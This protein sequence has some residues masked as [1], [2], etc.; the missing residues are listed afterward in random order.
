MS[1][2]RASG[3]GTRAW[4]PGVTAKPTVVALAASDPANPYG[5]A[6]RW[7]ATTADQAHK[8]T[9]K[10]GALVVLV[11]GEPVIYLERGGHT[12]LTW[13]TE[14]NL[15][16]AASGALADLVRTGRLASLTVAKI[17]ADSAI[18]SVVPLTKALVNV[19]FTLTPKGLR[20]RR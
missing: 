13:T 6:L 8:P 17:D 2:A 5:A 16:E 19:G 9:R 7:P 4:P 14:S 15:L 18:G 20:L 3:A 1:E 12:A 10:A 11:A